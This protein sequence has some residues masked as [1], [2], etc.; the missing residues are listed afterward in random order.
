M[1]NMRISGL[2]ANLTGSVVKVNPG[3]KFGVSKIAFVWTGPARQ[4]VFG[5]ALKP[6]GW[7]D[8]NNGDPV[9]PG[10]YALTAFNVA[11]KVDAKVAVDLA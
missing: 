5:L 1:K 4:L 2:Q 7:V 6:Y 11:N 9:I 8:F 10:A 3:D